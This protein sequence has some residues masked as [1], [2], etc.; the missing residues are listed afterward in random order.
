MNTKEYIK[1]LFTDYEENNELVDF[2][3][4]LQSN[5]D[6]RI[7]SLERKGLS[8]TD[9]FDKACAELGD[10]S[11]LAKELSLKKR[12][13]VF[14]EAYMDVRKY[15]T[16]GR[17]ASYVIFGVLA[18]LGISSGMIAFFAIRGIGM[19]LNISM[20][21][22]FGIT[23]PFL[24]AAA[25]GFTYLGVTQETATHYP[26]SNKRAAWYTVAATLIA[27]GVST[28]PLVYFGMETSSE[29]GANIFGGL[30]VIVSIIAMMIPF[31]LPGVGLLVFLVLTEKNRFKPWMASIHKN[32]L[33]KEMKMWSD[34][35]EASSFGM[36]VG[37][38]FIFGFALFILF[39]FIV[40]FR[41][42]W[43]VFLFA[44]AAQLLVQGLMM[45]KKCQA[46]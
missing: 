34:P 23:M 33:E 20:V 24:V 18:L 2:M 7:A 13:E 5:L 44:V 32:N 41:Y 27:F 11:V 3:E 40:G 29:F 30:N 39:G 8:E 36:I 6:A 31:V 38:I 16:A 19:S 28:M 43:L 21:S 14:E 45:K 12:R 9:A 35:A 4:E 37:S 1:S 15:M 42:S 46:E 10:I 25:A 17:V 26:V 22:L